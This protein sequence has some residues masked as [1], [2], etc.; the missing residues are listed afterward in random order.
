MNEIS[1]PEDVVRTLLIK[2][3]LNVNRTFEETYNQNPLLK[4]SLRQYLPEVD[5][6]NLERVAELL[7]ILNIF[8]KFAYSHKKLEDVAIL[9]DLWV[10]TSMTIAEE[11]QAQAAKIIIELQYILYKMYSHEETRTTNDL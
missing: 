11:H 7:A 5:D 10:R 2:A 3:G 1:N 6:K 4:E 8:N 9:T